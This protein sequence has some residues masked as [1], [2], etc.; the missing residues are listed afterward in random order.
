MPAPSYSAEAPPW[1]RT[2]DVTAPWDDEKENLTPAHPFPVGDDGRGM[3]AA[4]AQEA[5]AAQAEVMRGEKKQRKQRERE[6]RRR[7]EEH[8]RETSGAAAH[9]S[10]DYEE[11]ALEVERPAP[12]GQ[13]AA[14]RTQQ[15][16]PA[17]T[18]SSAPAIVIFVALLL[19]AI[20][21]YVLAKKEE[22]KEVRPKTPRARPERRSAPPPPE[23]PATTVPATEEPVP[24]TTKLTVSQRIGMEQVEKHSVVLSQEQLEKVKKVITHREK[25]PFHRWGAENPKVEVV[26]FAPFTHMG[27]ARLKQL[28]SEF[29]KLDPFQ[30]QIAVWFV[31]HWGPDQG[32]E[33][34]AADIANAIQW[35]F[36][37]EGMYHFVMLLQKEAIWR[38]AAN[39]K[40][41][42]YIRKVGL[43]P[44]KLRDQMKT[45]PL[46]EIRKEVSDLMADLHLQDKDLTFLIGGRSYL[47]GKTLY[48]VSKI[49]DYELSAREP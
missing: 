37:Q 12:S 36:K 4:D 10:P 7:E 23:E 26:V 3:S 41:D 16:A 11:V 29:K 24:A 9:P 18:A 49:V 47:D 48:N 21:G 34:E 38:V 46:V 40:L 39:N 32:L 33:A 8:H 31:F 45:I 44:V 20:G 14:R 35:T 17:S 19:L 28:N 22:A 1:E 25:Y 15:P 27:V 43:D 30:S 42:D 5:D 2:H 6:T 13:P